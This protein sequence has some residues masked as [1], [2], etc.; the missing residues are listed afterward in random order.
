MGLFTC[1]LDHVGLQ[2]PLLVKSFSTFTTFKWP[3][4]CVDP[5][6][7]RELTWLL[8]RLP[9]VWTRVCESTSVD[10]AIIGSRA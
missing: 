1:V 8:E 9:A 3:F 2:R 4:T 5:D 6:V 7:P 10:V